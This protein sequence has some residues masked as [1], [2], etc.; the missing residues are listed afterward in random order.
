MPLPTITA[1]TCSFLPCM[2]RDHGEKRTNKSSSSR[3]NSTPTLPSFWTVR[4][5]NPS[6][7]MLAK[8][9]KSSFARVIFL[10]PWPS[11]SFNRPESNLP[12]SK[13]NSRRSR[14]TPPRKC[15]PTPQ[16]PAAAPETP[17]AKGARAFKS[18]RS[19]THPKSP[20]HTCCEKALSNG[21][22]HPL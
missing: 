8:R 22:I 9:S 3:K 19:R 5:P 2:R 16:D 12:F 10:I 14:S 18:I 17:A 20:H 15:F 6:P 1:A 13:S 11:A 4:W 7:N 21:I